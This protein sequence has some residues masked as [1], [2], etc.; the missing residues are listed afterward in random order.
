MLINAICR[1]YPEEILALLKGEGSTDD[2]N[3]LST[4]IFCT[5]SAIKKIGRFTEAPPNGIVYRGL[6]NMLLPQSFWLPHGDPAWRGGVERAVMSTTL[7]KAVALFYAGGRGTLIE[8]RVCRAQM[9]G[10]I[11]LLSQVDN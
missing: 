2:H 9:G 4:L 5:T 6:G 8:I 11:S 1:S 3:T 10:S 7:D